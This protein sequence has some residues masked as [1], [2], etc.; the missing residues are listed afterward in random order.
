MSDRSL[1]SVRREL[2]TL[3]KDP[4]LA[5]NDDLI[6][7][8]LRSQPKVMKAASKALHRMALIKLIH[9][10]AGSRSRVDASQFELFEGVSYPEFVWIR[11]YDASGRISGNVRKDPMDLTLEE[12]DQLLAEQSKPAQREKKKN[13]G[14]IKMAVACRPHMLNGGTVREALPKADAEARSA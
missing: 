8:L 1:D 3:L 14:L 13:A 2:R 5:S 10:V 9:D 6:D 4:R 12:V 11:T 7:E